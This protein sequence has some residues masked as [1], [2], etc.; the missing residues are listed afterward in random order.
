M[1]SYDGAYQNRPKTIYP[2]GW[3]DICSCDEEV[4][5]FCSFHGERG[6]KRVEEYRK[7]MSKLRKEVDN[8]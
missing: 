4:N 5:T 2:G 7:E 8:D 3:N 6:K 1:S